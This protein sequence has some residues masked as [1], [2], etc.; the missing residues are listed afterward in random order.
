MVNVGVTG[1][2][3]SGKTTVC[4][5]WERKGAFVVYSDA[6]AKK[7]MTGDKKL[8]REIRKEFGEKAYLPDGTLNREFLAE[9]AFQQNQVETLNRMVHPV[10][11]N[12]VQKLMK[13]AK[14][15]EIPMFVQEAA[16]L[17]NDG[18]PDYLDFIVL[19]TA[20]KEHRVHWVSQRD[21]LTE[22]EILSRMN[23]QQDFNQLEPLCDVIIINDSTV[24]ELKKK[25]ANLFDQL[26][27]S[28]NRFQ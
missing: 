20:K 8:V 1:G 22:E 17:L 18:R 19:V 9:A 11:R 23:K 6:L 16:L 5:V 26:L 7:L 14:K 25:A 21:Q 27:E 12:F 28:G 15:D 13:Q 10:V 4:K 24:S 3:G 2:I